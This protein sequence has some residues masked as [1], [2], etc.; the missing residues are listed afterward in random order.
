M[1]K[2]VP[3]SLMRPGHGQQAASPHFDNYNRHFDN[4]V[5]QPVMMDEN[6]IYAH[7][8]QYSQPPFK[9]V[10][11]I[12]KILGTSGGFREYN[13]YWRWDSQRNYY[14][15]VYDVGNDQCKNVQPD[16][17]S[18]KLQWSNQS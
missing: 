11:V 2:Y 15:L 5:I 4:I 13:V 17:A 6:K 14:E 1:S 10:E 7:R 3:R 18:G 16:I 12:Q 8:A 9:K